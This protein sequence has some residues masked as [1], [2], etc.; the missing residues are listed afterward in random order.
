MSSAMYEA[1]SQTIFAEDSSI[2]HSLNEGVKSLTSSMFKASAQSGISEITN[3]ISGGMW[4]SDNLKD[5]EFNAVQKM[6]G[7]VNEADI[8]S[9][10]LSNKYLYASLIMADRIIHKEVGQL[11]KNTSIELY[12]FA[13]DGDKS[14]FLT[15]NL[16]ETNLDI[17]IIEDK[18]VEE[19]ARLPSRPLNG[20]IVISILAD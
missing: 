6:Y 10:L 14:L 8:K 19:I 12:S 15:V 2:A 18:I 13:E 5:T 3:I 11:F 9:Y 4:E 20:K 1:S 7:L 16:H 17:D